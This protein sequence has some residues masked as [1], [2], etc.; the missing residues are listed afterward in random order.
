MEE[1]SDPCEPCKKANAVAQ[2]GY[3]KRVYINGG[4]LMLDASG[5]RRR[6]M[7]LSSIG[8]NHTEIARKLGTDKSVIGNL[9]SKKKRSVYPATAEKIRAVYDELSMIPP[10]LD[11]DWIAKRTAKEARRRGYPSPLAWDDESIDDPYVLPMGLTPHQAALWFWNCATMTERIQW[12]L[13]HGLSVT[14]MADRANMSRSQRAQQSTTPGATA[15]RQWRS[16]PENREKENER[17][18]AARAAKKEAVPS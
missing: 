12:V 7:G 5:T 1:G 17:K 13:E 16:K 14:R 2:D 8:Y 15:H 10:D 3:R 18:R 6:I 9:N 11:E 4:K